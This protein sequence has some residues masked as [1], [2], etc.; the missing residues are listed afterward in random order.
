MSIGI[1]R[2]EDAFKRKM[3]PKNKNKRI[4][5]IEDYFFDKHD[6]EVNFEADEQKCLDFILQYAIDEEGPSEDEIFSDILNIL[7][8]RYSI[9]EPFYVSL[10]ELGTTTTFEELFELLEEQLRDEVVRESFSFNEFNVSADQVS[11]RV[12]IT[13]RF[14]E[15]YKHILTEEIEREKK[16]YSGNLV[17]N[18]DFDNSVAVVTKSSYNKAVNQI[19]GFIDAVIVSLGRI[20][21]YYVQNKVRGNK[22]IQDY[23]IL[24]LITINLIYDKLVQFDYSVL[25]VISLSFNNNGAPRIKN[26]KLGGVDLFQDL[27]IVARIHNKDR[28]TSFAIKIEKT[29]SADKKMEALLTVDFRGTLKVLIDEITGNNIDGNDLNDVAYEIYEILSNMIGKEEEVEQGRELFEQRILANSTPNPAIEVYK[30]QIKNELIQL[31]PDKIKE[32]EQYFKG[33]S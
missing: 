33:K 26:A 7:E 8:D 30:D 11:K 24:S 13:C 21:P 29:I 9:G 23:D 12:E 19:I 10:I 25:N 2:F 3:Y 28:I 4:E 20:K 16:L 15:Y 6:I 1:G 31:L 32:I 14:T 5:A 22:S 18:I 17:I 27:D